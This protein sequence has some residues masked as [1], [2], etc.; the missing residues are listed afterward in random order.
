VPELAR[1]IGHELG[2][3]AALLDGYTELLGP[4]VQESPVNGLRDTTARLRE[5]YE[6][7]F[8]LAQVASTAP[9]R[10]AVDPAAVLAAAL[11][12]LRERPGTP[13]ADVDIDVPPLPSVLADPVQLEQLFVHLLRS[14]TRTATAGGRHGLSVRGSRQGRDVRLDM[15]GDDS[16]RASA[17]RR[18]AGSLV[19]RGVVLALPSHIA[20]RNGGHLWVERTDRSGPMISL[21]LPAAEP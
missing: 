20:A 3:I 2:E 9:E 12:R 11:Q 6:D 4:S 1:V 10:S 21:T 18:G 13:A 5:V 19:G 15:G 16:P 8:E 7:L 14:A 17:D